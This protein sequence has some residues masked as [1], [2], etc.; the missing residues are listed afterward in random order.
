MTCD[1][2]RPVY[3]SLIFALCSSLE[4]VLD[5]RTVLWEG[6][7][8]QYGGGRKC[9][10][11]NKV[12]E[13]ADILLFSHCRAVCWHIPHMMAS[14]RYVYM[15]GRAPQFWQNICLCS[16]LRW[17][18]RWE[19][20]HPP[21]WALLWRR[22]CPSNTYP[23]VIYR[24]KQSLALKHVI[25]RWKKWKISHLA[26]GISKSTELLSLNQSLRICWFAPCLAAVPSQSKWPVSSIKNLWLLRCVFI[27]RKLYDNKVSR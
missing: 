26:S 1:G 6:K 14:D 15:W 27:L 13:G 20:R 18:R 10:M 12:T 7:R 3:K 21:D 22:L 11:N 2:R 16:R 8:M 9:L 4:I 25:K 23:H 17:A 5:L 24:W 19:S